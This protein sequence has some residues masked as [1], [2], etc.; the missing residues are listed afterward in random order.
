MLTFHIFIEICEKFAH[1]Y[2]MVFPWSASWLGLSLL[3]IPWIIFEYLHYRVVDWAEVKGILSDG[4]YVVMLLIACFC[5]VCFSFQ[6]RRENWYV[7]ELG[8]SRVVIGTSGLLRRAFIAVSLSISG[9]VMDAFGQLKTVSFAL[10]L[11]ALAFLS[12][13]LIQ[14]PWLILVVDDFQSAA[15]ALSYSSLAVHFSKAGSKASSAIIQG[16][17]AIFRVQWRL[18]G[19]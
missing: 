6:V 10:F 19:E 2:V 13:L 11:Y 15:F 17:D 16:K 1:G 7:L 8:G 5:S 3:S 12:F 14:T 18:A 9:I 4:H